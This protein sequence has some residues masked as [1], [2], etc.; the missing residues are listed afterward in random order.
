MMEPWLAAITI[1]T[2]PLLKAGFNPRLGIDKQLQAEMERAGKP[3]KGFET[4]REQLMYLV[5][6]PESV[7]LAF[8]RGA[9]HDYA[10]AKAELMAIVQAWKTGDVHALAATVVEK[11]K[12]HSPKLYRAL[13]VTRNKNWSHQIAQLMQTTPGTI[14]IAVGS[15]HLVGPD[16]LQ[17]QLQKLGIHAVRIAR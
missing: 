10:N 3:V 7:Q 16:R 2:T 1:A 6:L 17:V 13:I 9:L 8:L 5:K 14:F 15:G 12:N 11:M 4:A